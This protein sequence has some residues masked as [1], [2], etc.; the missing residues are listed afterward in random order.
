M[1][2]MAEILT[3]L[4]NQILSISFNRPEK[5]NALTR[6]MYGQLAE[7]LK[8]ADQ[9]FGIRAV[10]LTSEGSHFTAGNDITDFLEHPP[11]SEDSTVA[12]FLSAIHNFT[13]PLLAAV[14]G[15]AIGVGTTLLLHCDL[16]VAAEEAKFALPFTSLGLVPEA[17]SSFLLPRL[18][19]YQRAAEL[20]LI[21]DNFDAEYAHQIG[22]V[23]YVANDPYEKARELALKIAAQ[24][25]Q[26]VINTKALMKA[27][28]HD[29]VAAVMK[30]EFEIFAMALQSDEAR[31]AFINFMNR[32]NQKKGE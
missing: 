29:S 19:G 14:K 24:P 1:L 20:F 22:L 6:A 15:N 9:E 26:A 28:V 8:S 5:M 3:I 12:A 27:Q 23:N 2:A 21:G 30:A 7:E 32:K 31:S 11:T 18:V 17:G 13:K 16:V 10:I 4:E 25:P